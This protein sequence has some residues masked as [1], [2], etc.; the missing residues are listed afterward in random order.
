MPAPISTI[1]AIRSDS[2]SRPIDEEAVAVCLRRVELALHRGCRDEAL[3][4]LDAAFAEAG[5]FLKDDS[6][7]YSLNVCQRTANLLYECGF[8]TLAELRI[9]LV[10]GQIAAIA[11]VGQTMFEECQEAVRLADEAW[12][13]VLGD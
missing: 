6:S 13:D 5:D 8:R 3:S 4:A 9:G 10:N 12:D 1:D 11:G 7:V 2:R